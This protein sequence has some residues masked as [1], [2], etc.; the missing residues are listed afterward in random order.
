MSKLTK[1]CLAAGLLALALSAHA[2]GETGLTELRRLV[3]A[4]QFEAAYQMAQTQAQDKQ[5]AGPH[6]D[7]LLGLSAVNSGHFAQGVVALER[8]LAAV[9]AN[10][11]ARL[12]LARASYELG[13]YLRAR[14]E[15]EFVLRY[16]PP[17]DVQVNVQK[18][19]DAMQ[20]R[21]I[22]TSRATSRSY[23]QI[24]AGYDSNVN[25]GTYAN[26]MDSLG[27]PVPLTDPAARET[28]SSFT[29]IVAGTQWVR[30]VDSNLA[31]FAGGD[32]DHK[33]NPDASAYDTSNIGGYGGF[34]LS[35]GPGLY[36][37]TLSESQFQLNNQKYRNTLSLT[38]EG[39][40]TLESGYLLNAVAQYSELSHANANL[41]RDSKL[42]TLGGGVQKT[43]AAPWRPTLGVQLTQAHEGNL[44]MRDDLSRDATTLRVSLAA[45]PSERLGLSMGLSGQ[46][47]KFGQADLAI[48]TVRNDQTQ[49]LDLGVNYLWSRNW[50]LRFDAQLTDNQS[51]QALYTYRR[52][53]VGLHTRYLF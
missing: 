53:F 10:D 44:H 7:F 32:F 35:R 23:V 2:A 40:Y 42:T 34:S 26:Q 39:Q 38:G 3:E 6:L 5:Q 29:Q 8:H 28:G 14:R 19:L 16:N 52:S 1:H 17:K 13:D 47:N 51:N 25:A 50:L 27:G 18:Y 37:M 41:I 11:R 15:F 30:R 20:T 45:S 31:V 48:G 49:T 22:G 36:R 21:D 4:G 12:E 9:P 33:G 43:L 24:G 46:Q